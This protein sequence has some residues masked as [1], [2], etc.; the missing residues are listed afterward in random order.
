MHSELMKSL[1][2]K[3]AG[4]MGDLGLPGPDGRAGVPGQD[5]EQ[6]EPAPEIRKH[7]ISKITFLSVS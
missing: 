1:K 3:S 4:M 7:P 5:G 2:F 6:G